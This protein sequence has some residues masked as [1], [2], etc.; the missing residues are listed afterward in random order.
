MLR[1]EEL[2]D[3]DEDAEDEGGEDEGHRVQLPGSLPQLPVP[4]VRLSAKFGDF[5]NESAMLREVLT[6]QP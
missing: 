1:L 2:G 6:P 3:V 5:R 4:G